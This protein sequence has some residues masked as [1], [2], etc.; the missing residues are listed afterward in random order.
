VTDVQLTGREGYFT[1]VVAAGP[2]ARFRVW[3]PFDSAYSP[4]LVVR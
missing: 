3:S 4:T 2:G 1:Q